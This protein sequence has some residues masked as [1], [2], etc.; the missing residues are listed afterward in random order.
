M[1]RI[2]IKTVCKRYCDTAIVEQ[3][4]LHTVLIITYCWTSYYDHSQMRDAGL[5]D[6]F[7]WNEFIRHIPV[8]HL[9]GNNA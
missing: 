1:Q 3:Y 6:K 5:V 9:S 2:V 4:L 8:A 7:V